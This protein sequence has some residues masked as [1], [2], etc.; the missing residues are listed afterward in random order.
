MLNLKKLYTS[1][2]TSTYFLSTGRYLLQKS[3]GANYQFHKESCSQ[4]KIDMQEQDQNQDPNGD[5]IKGI[6]FR[7]ETAIYKQVDERGGI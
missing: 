7:I 1:L 4:C 3:T 6:V 2:S 5:A